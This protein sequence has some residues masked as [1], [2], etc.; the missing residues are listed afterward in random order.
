MAGL[1]G[2]HSGLN[3]GKRGSSGLVVGMDTHICHHVVTTTVHLLVTFHL[4]MHTLYNI[5]GSVIP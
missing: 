5:I 4:P 3:L 1:L 2:F